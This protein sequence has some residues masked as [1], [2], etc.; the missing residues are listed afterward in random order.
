MV[1]CHCRIVICHC[2]MVICHCHI[3]IC[4]CHIVICHCRIV[5]CHF[6]ILIL[7]KVVQSIIYLDMCIYQCHYSYML[8]K[9]IIFPFT[10]TIYYLYSC[11]NDALCKI[12]YMSPNFIHQLI[13]NGSNVSRPGHYIDAFF[14][15]NYISVFVTLIIIL[16]TIQTSRNTPLLHPLV[17]KP[18][19][20]L[21]LHECRLIILYTCMFA[22]LFLINDRYWYYKQCNNNKKCVLNLIV[23]I[24]YT[25]NLYSIILFKLAYLLI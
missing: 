18:Q 20:S 23:N 15:S 24:N 16:L 25:H 21:I 11:H 6:L 8:I 7:I 10:R 9:E 12:L 5:I 3:V 2:H 22:I 4:H 17:L 13:F 19:P 1:I 14:T